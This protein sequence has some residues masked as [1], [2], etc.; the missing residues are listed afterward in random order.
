MLGDRLALAGQQRLVE[1][2]PDG[3]DDV[4]VDD[5]LVAR[6]QHEEFVGD[7]L[8]HREFDVV[9]VTP[10]QRLRSVQELE[11]VQRVA[12]PELLHDA[13]DRVGDDDARKQGVLRKPGD[14]DQDEQR[15]DDGVDRRE[16]VGAHDL[17]QRANRSVGHVV[18]ASVGAPFG[19]LR[20]GQPERGVDRRGAH[21]P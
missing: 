21:P 6:P 9:A 12:R 1:V 13:D 7:D 10:R 8:A 11:L 15:R 19:H 16:D 18:G 14:Q 17:A 4:T 20:C 5:H 3:G 2:E